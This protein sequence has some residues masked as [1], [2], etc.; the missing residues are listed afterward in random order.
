MRFFLLLLPWLEL[1]TLIQ[2]GVKTSALTALLY[3]LATFFLGLVVLRK[4]GMEMVQRL[5]DANEGR[6]LGP[7]L[8]MDD[9]AV[10][11]AGLLLLVPGLI[12]DI[13]AVLVM[14]GPLRRRLARAL[15]GPRPE[16]YRPER[17][18]HSQVTLEGQYRRVD[19]DDSSQPIDL[20][21]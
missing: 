4:Q 14:V 10:G 19:P 21:E 12:T 15:A 13:A 6:V 11:L 2:L 17:D 1:F 9:M 7:E 5:R 8:L 16:V 18:P 20:K 3:V